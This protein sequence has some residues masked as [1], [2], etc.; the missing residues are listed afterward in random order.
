[1]SLR[2]L[3]SWMMTLILFAVITAAIAY[4]GAGPG[5]VFSGT[6]RAIDGDSL[7]IGGRRGRLFGIDA[8][9]YGQT[10]K[11]AGETTPCGRLAHAELKLLVSRKIWNVRVLD[12]IVM[13]EH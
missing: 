9:E 11:K 6:A 1:M 12:L 13:I 2:A 5:E 7:E 4:L 8:P 10:C 3:R